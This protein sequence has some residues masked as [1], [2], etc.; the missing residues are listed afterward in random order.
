[1]KA[2]I[3]VDGSVGGFEAVRQAGQLLPPDRSQV[4]LYYSPPSIKLNDGAIEPAVL[5][6]A[7]ALLA[8]A[9]FDEAKALLSDPLRTSAESILSDQPARQG[10]VAAA[11][12]VGANLIAVGARGLGPIERLLLGSVSTSVVHTARVPVLVAR[13]RPAD[14]QQQ[15]LRV[16]IAFGSASDDGHLADVIKTFRWPAGTQGLTVSVVQSMFAGHVPVWLEERARSEEVEA[17]ARAWVAEHTLEI[18][19]KRSE[20]A[21]FDDTLPEPWRPEQPMVVE[22]HPA[23]QILATI[24]EKKIDLVVTGAGRRSAVTRFFMG[25]TSRTVLNQA[26]CSVLIVGAAR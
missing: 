9:V 4:V 3:A 24:S 7:R 18:N 15:P 1:M 20:A 26:S 25:S 12:S 22:G 8:R 11:E 16:L 17:M 19:N 10:I 14:R 5:D 21:A 23:D 6:R 2:L 13:P